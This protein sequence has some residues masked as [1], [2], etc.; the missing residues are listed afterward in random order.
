MRIDH[1]AWDRDSLIVMFDVQLAVRE[2][3]ACEWGWRATQCGAHV[4]GRLCAASQ[5]RW[6]VLVIV[7]PSL[8]A[9][10]CSWMPLTYCHDRTRGEQESE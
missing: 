8:T 6:K 5:L 10:P 7:V 9:Q 1:N 4:R 3:M 2:A